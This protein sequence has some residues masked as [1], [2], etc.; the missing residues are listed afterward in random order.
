M[1]EM[2]VGAVIDGMADLLYGFEG[3]SNQISR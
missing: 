2:R 1:V 3:K